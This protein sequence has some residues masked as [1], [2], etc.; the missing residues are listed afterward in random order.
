MHFNLYNEAYRSHCYCLIDTFSSGELPISPW[1]HSRFYKADFIKMLAKYKLANN[2][3]FSDGGDS[4]TSSS[5]G[6]GGDIDAVDVFIREYVERRSSFVK[7]RSKVE[8]NT[9]NFGL[10]ISM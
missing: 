2:K 4:D 3:S 1:K 10:S 6:V 7:V 5:D 9:Q 8:S